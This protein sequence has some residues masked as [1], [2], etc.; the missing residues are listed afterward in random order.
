MASAKRNW[1]FEMEMWRND[2]VWLPFYL[3]RVYIDDAGHSF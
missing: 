2:C 1:R 3:V